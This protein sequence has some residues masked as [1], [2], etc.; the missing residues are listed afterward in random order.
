MNKEMKMY[1]FLQ[2]EYISEKKFLV[3]NMM[4]DNFVIKRRKKHLGLAFTKIANSAYKLNSQSIE[5]LRG[6][7][8]VLKQENLE[9]LRKFK[10]LKKRLSKQK[11][12][13]M[14]YKEDSLSKI[15]L[16]FS[17]N[18]VVLP[19]NKQRTSR[20]NS[21]TTALLTDKAFLQFYKDPKNTKDLSQNNIVE[22]Y[23]QFL[24]K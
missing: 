18:E 14:S 2:A 21:V 4:V 15:S 16:S 11:K 7:R 12:L 5:D 24:I 19:K 23:K 8:K 10:T 17:N 6:N 1:N 22:L 3:F 13:M 20:V 9:L